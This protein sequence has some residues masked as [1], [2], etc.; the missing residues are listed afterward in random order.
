[1]LSSTVWTLE[2]YWDDAGSWEYSRL[3]Y[4]PTIGNRWYIVHPRKVY[5]HRHIKYNIS[6]NSVSRIREMICR[7]L[8]K[9]EDFF[10]AWLFIFHDKKFKLLSGQIYSLIHY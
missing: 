1:M 2:E 7:V 6:W 8:I 10:G 9:L 5:S 3:L 4:C